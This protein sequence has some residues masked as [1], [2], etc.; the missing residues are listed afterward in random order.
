MIDEEQRFGVT[1]KEKIKQMKESV[2]VLTLTA[3]PIPRTLH[4]SLIGIRDMSVLEEPPLDRVPIQTYVMEY[5]EEMVREAISRELA[6][7]GQVYYVYN[8]VNNIVE[9]TNRIAALVPEANVAFAHG[10]MKERELEQIMY[11]FI[12]GDIDVLVSTTIIETG[13]DI[14]NVNT[15]IIHDADQM[16]LSQL[17]QLRGRVGRANRTA[18]AFLM[19]RR[20][21]ML[22]EVAEKRLHAIR[23]FTELGSGVKIAM[24]DL[25]IRG[26]GNLLG[27]EQHGHMEAVG[28]DLYCK[29]LSEAVKEAK[30]IHQQEDFETSIDLV[31]DAFIP[32]G[33]IPNEGQKLDVYKRIASIENREEAEDMLEELLDRFGEP[34]RSVQNLLAVAELKAL[35]HRAYVTE[36][37]QTGMEI[38]IT[39]Y[40]KARLDVQG[41]P[42]LLE[43]YG[44]K[45]K[46]KI[47]ANPYFLYQPGPP[48]KKRETVL[49]QVR[50]F[51]EDLSRYVM[52]DES[53]GLDQ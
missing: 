25:E 30:G 20:N 27:A 5:D 52:T 46:F 16:G 40:E 49:D 21:R 12:N 35:A 11:S 47:E 22:K 6:R 2:D 14:S 29:M 4:M 44:R 42:S 15:I 7:G 3:T 28:Y 34:P 48:K 41:I 23:E 39:F 18:Y 1:H 38:K 36:I 53:F 13:M 51:M 24:R 10:Q 17:Y 31:M 32:P 45:L 9:L 8:R 43:Q 19:Y 33:Y 50:G 26:A 37:K